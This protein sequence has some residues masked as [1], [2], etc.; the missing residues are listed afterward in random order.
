MVANSRSN[1]RWQGEVTRVPTAVITDAEFADF[2]WEQNFF[3]E[4]GITLVVGN[5]RTPQEAAALAAD[6]DAVI[7]NRCPINREVIAHLNRCRIIVRYGVG[8][9]NVDIAAATEKG[10]IVCN[11]PDYS[12]N[13]VATHA[14][15]LLLCCWRKVHVG[16]AGLK[17]SEWQNYRTIAPVH[18]TIGKTVGLFGFGR[19]ARRVAELLY[20]FGFR[21]IAF[22]PY[23][24]DE[25]MLLHG[26]EKVE[27]A[28]LLE[29]SDAISVHAPLTDETRG[30][31][32]RDAF[33]R[34]KRGI[35]FVNTARGGLVDEAAL[36][37]ALDEGIV[38]AAGLDVFVNEPHPDPRLVRHPKVIATPHWAWYSEE[39]L[40][41]LRR[42][43]AEQVVQALKGERPTYAL[44]FEAVM[45]KK[46][47]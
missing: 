31:F 10:I 13:E 22:D 4:H 15:A 40:W 36:L 43:V 44:N 37:W 11:V 30:I 35:V 46:S 7:T 23:V 47:E 25:E 18:R 12:V 33:A 41:E 26:T 29:R 3:A 34:M 1:N 21:P 19:I 32:N 42:K 16:D 6:A 14:V 17:R 27:F 45:A 24:P 39:A 28:A 5:C 38:A 2:S 9:D 20:P 8:V